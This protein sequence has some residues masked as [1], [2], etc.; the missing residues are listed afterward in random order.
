MYLSL[1]FYKIVNS[2]QN[3]NC[4]FFRGL[5]KGFGS[6]PLR[7]SF[8]PSSSIKIILPSEWLFSNH[9]VRYSKHS[10]G[11]PG[12]SCNWELNLG[13]S[14]KMYSSNRFH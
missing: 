6:F 5:L 3:L 10:Q 7:T 4:I 14:L 11:T 12:R 8:N 13:C 2:S 1:Q 9:L